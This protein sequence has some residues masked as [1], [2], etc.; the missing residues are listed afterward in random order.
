M[1]AILIYESVLGRPLKVSTTMSGFE[2]LGLCYSSF[3]I[4][5]ESEVRELVANH[6]LLRYRLAIKCLFI[7]DLLKIFFLRISF[8]NNSTISGPKK[9]A[10][11]LL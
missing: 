5:F 4:K 11:Y 7:T 3:T 6:L 1:I 2:N 10:L 9:E 8:R